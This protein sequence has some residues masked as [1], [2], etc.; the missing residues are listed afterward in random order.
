MIVHTY[1][2]IYI[3]KYIYRHTYIYAYTYIES[4]DDNEDHCSEEVKGHLKDPM[5]VEGKG[6]RG[7]DSWDDDDLLVSKPHT[8]VYI[9]IYI[10]MY[11]YICIYT[12]V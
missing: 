12:Y 4:I 7:G 10:Y 11:I 5:G 9:Y 6:G 1:I 8:Q 2:H 3:R